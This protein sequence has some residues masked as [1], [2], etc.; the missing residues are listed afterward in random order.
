MSNN[1]FK[2]LMNMKSKIYK[3][4]SLFLLTTIY[5]GS[6]TVYSAN[7]SG[8][9]NPDIK[10]EGLFQFQ[11]GFV[12]QDNLFPKEKYLSNYKRGVLFFTESTLAATVSKTVD[13]MI[14]GGKLVLLPTT[15]AKTSPNYNG[16]H[17][18]IETEYGKVELGSP[19]DAA[20][21][22]R[23]T[24]DHIVAATGST[25]N[26]SRYANLQFENMRKHNMLYP[27]FAD[28]SEYF[29]DSVFKHQLNQINDKTEPSRK[30]SYY[31]PNYKGLQFGISYIP[32]PSNTGCLS[33]SDR[34]KLKTGI[35]EFSDLEHIY[36]H[37][38]NVKDALSLGL[39]Y[40]FNIVDNM[41]LKL[42]ATGEYAKTA[43]T[44]KFQTF[45]IEDKEKKNPISEHKISSL[46]TYNLG[47]VLTHGNFSYAL[48]C[49]SLGKS[50]NAKDKN[51]PHSGTWYYNGAIAYT[52]GPIKTS[53]SYFKSEKFKNTVDSVAMGTEYKLA[54]GLSPYAEVTYFHAKSKYYRYTVRARARGAI[55]LIGAKLKF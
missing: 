17:I 30:I 5:T 32:D 7:L 10:L 44:I 22:M 16:S 4:L 41:D 18:F 48:S 43:S 50:L 37:N 19:Y 54:P 53:V 3:S 6:G 47:A 36:V 52:R 45:N 8:I 42:S 34:S 2:N 14:Y 25:G 33:M 51:Y 29:L 23:I 28:S 55:T 20:S 49:G 11:S 27:V 1:F 13:D 39:T 40:K 12:N 26:W 9:S 46:R 35:N 15:K 24:G 21:K 31:T 38:Q